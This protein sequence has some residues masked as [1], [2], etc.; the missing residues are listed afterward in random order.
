MSFSQCEIKDSPK[1]DLVRYLAKN[2]EPRCVRILLEVRD[3]PPHHLGVG[4]NK[5]FSD[6]GNLNFVSSYNTYLL[7]GA[8]QG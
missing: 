1:E 8:R 5:N 4:P 6:N 2:A 3:G 7:R